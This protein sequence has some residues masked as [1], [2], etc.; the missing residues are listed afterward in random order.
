F[1]FTGINKKELL[2]KAH[3]LL[4]NKEKPSVNTPLFRVD[5]KRFTLPKL[6]VSLMEDAF[7][8]ME[9]IGFPLCSPFSL[10]D[11]DF[12]STM[13]TKDLKHQ[14]GKVITILG[15]LIAIKNTSTSN[16]KRMNFGTF[17]DME[18][19]FIDTVHFP[20][21]AER[22]PFRGRGVYAI[23]G[24]VVEEYDFHSIEVMMMEKER[25]IDD[26]RYSVNSG[27]ELNI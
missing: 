21:S 26:P 23:T 17:I 18:G 11:G 25:Y 24:K 13:C 12:K 7:D 10:L 16:G 9:F 6:S 22:W 2:W 20:P 5:Y 4:G 27:N 15:Y 3:F 19:Q 8:E 1:R 14:T